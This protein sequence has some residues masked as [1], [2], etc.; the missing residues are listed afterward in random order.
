MS[1][2]SLLTDAHEVTRAGVQI[3][4]SPP[5]QAL[6][7]YQR[8]GASCPRC[9][10]STTCGNIR[11]WDGE[12]HA[13]VESYISYLRPK[14]AVK[15]TSGEL[16]H[17]KRG[18]GYILRAEGNVPQSGSTCR[19]LVGHQAPHLQ[20]TLITFSCRRTCCRPS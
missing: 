3:D 15:G 13:I 10:S 6:P 19:G 5:V 12:G 20:L 14:L 9:R 18:V 7:R 8:R 11:L 2:T 16:I 1:V 17:T 4:L